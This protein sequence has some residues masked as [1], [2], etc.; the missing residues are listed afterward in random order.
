MAVPDIAKISFE[1]SPKLGIR[2]LPQLDG[3]HQSNVPGLYV[4]GDLADAPI[5]KVALNQG[6]E[7]ASTVCAELGAPSSDPD[8]LDVVIVGAGPAGIGAALALQEKGYRYVLLE[9]ERPFNTI[10]NF[11]KAKLIFSEPRTLENKG[12][13]WFEDATKEELVDRWGEALESRQL[14]LHQ[15][16]EVVDIPK[17]GGVFEVRTKV[18]A[19]G[20]MGEYTRHGGA[21]DAS[22]GAQNTYR[23]KRI[24][25]A[26]G[27]RADV[28]RLDIPGEELDKVAYVL[29]DPDLHKGRKV[30]VVG[31]GDSAVEAA[32]AC[33]E[34][35]A[36]VTISYRQNGFHRAKAGNQEKIGK[37]IEAGRIRAELGTAPVEITEDSVKLKRGDTVVDIPNDDVM[38]FIGTKLAKGFLQRV[39]IRMAGEMTLQRGAWIATFMVLTYLFYLMKGGMKG[40]HPKW[41][42]WPMG[43]GQPLE[44][45]HHLLQLDLGFRS[46]DGAFWGTAFYSLL[47]TVFGIRAYMRYPSPTQK[48]RYMSLIGF[49]LLFL[50]GIP[51]IIAP[52]VIKGSPFVADLFGGDRGWRFYGISVPWPLNIWALIDGQYWPTVSESSPFSQ[53]TV[54]IGWILVGAFVSFVLMPLFVWRN[55]EKF[56][57]YLCGCGGLAET[58]G[59]FWRHLAPRGR[60]AVQAE[61]M[62]RIVFLAAIPV[63][64]LILNDAWGFFAKDALYSTKAFAEHWYGLMVDFWLA[65]VIGVAFYPYLGNRV[66]CRFFCPLRAYMEM[67]SKYIGRL[68]IHANDKCIGCGECTRFCQMGIPVQEFAQKKEA[69]DNQTSACI[70]CGIC[71]EVCPMEV[72]ELRPKEPVKLAG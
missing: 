57:S 70:Q 50:F 14:V 10:Q 12:S 58:V 69:F 45:V 7:V 17:N 31:G 32:I 27:R 5:I 61:W 63:T 71:V 48:K 47:I 36:E 33:A 3:K 44:F 65:S 2:E 72:L 6:Y 46:I 16:E 19:G 13:F 21:H 34:S 28:N 59:D 52:L 30:L 40:D 55:N 4:V 38:V 66:W 62:G 56:C 18:G 42:F 43:T 49:Q 41:D 35:G 23:A 11:P 60:T 64:L 37:L 20:L 39:G 8:L 67:L 25:L 24:I 1:F 9:K 22:A 53:T 51:E 54:A 68:A 29:R 15:P 26:I